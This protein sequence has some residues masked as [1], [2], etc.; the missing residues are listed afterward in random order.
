M[1]I[2]FFSRAANKEDVIASLLPGFQSAHA[3]T[4]W[5]EIHEIE[6]GALPF[7]VMHLAIHPEDYPTRHISH[8]TPD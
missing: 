4:L 6:W 2:G 8:L 7:L 5:D 3:H 1:L